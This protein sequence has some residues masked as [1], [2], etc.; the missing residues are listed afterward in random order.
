VEVQLARVAERVGPGPGVMFRLT[1]A[2]VL[3]A[4]EG[5]MGA[6][7]VVEMLAA[8]SSR[9]LPAN[10]QRQVRDWMGAVRRVRVRPALLVECPDA[11]TAARVRAAGGARVREVTATLLELTDASRAERAA[12]AKKLRAG[13]VFVTDD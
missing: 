10:V 12:L 9:P 8:A 11:E 6:E 13:G 3:A 2:S 4:A 5:G 7:Q 1:R